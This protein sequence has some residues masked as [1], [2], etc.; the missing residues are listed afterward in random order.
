[1]AKNL[2]RAVPVFPVVVT[3][4]AAPNS[5]DPVRVGI[6]AGV[7]LTDEGDGGVELATE[8]VVDFRDQVWDILVDDSAASGIA[9]G[10]LLYYHDT[11]TGTPTTSVNNSS[12]SADAVFGVALGTITA[13]GT[14]IINVRLAGS[15]A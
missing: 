6:Q 1:M 5:G 14:E 12:A 7:A 4:P 3:H 9:P 2:V 13:N 10:D 15:A 8:T 11:G